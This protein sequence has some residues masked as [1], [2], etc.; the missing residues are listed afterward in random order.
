[1]L[2]TPQFR[3]DEGGLIGGVGS[4]GMKGE[5]GK[6]WGGGNNDEVGEK[7]K[8]EDKRVEWREGN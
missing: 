3:S 1:M 4:G 6:K 8:N 5:G 7:G 2:F